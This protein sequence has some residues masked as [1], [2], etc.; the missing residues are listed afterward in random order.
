MDVF[1]FPL[2]STLENIL[3]NCFDLSAT[4]KRK[5]FEI[6]LHFAGNEL[7]KEKLMEFVSPEGQDE[8]RFYAQRTRKSASQVFIDF[9]ASRPSLEYL[10]E[11]LPPMRPRAFSIASSCR[12]LNLFVFFFFEKIFIY[13][14][15]FSRQDPL[16]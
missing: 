13:Y 1:D 8:L 10:L 5:F 2:P 11:M 15:F 6:L 12:V 16:N 9:P 4:P 14:S 7:E 3:E